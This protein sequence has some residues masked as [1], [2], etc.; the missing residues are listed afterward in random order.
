MRYWPMLSR[1]GC[2]WAAFRDFHML[3][4]KPAIEILAMT[5]EIVER[6]R[7]FG[8]STRRYRASSTLENNNAP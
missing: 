7:E 2:Q 4:E 3:F 6:V 1:S 8:G 5:N